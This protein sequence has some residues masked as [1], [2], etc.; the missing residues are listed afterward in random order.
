MKISIITATYNCA[1]TIKDALDSVAI[2]THLDIEHLIIDGQSV[3]ET[4]DIV[5][6]YPS[7]NITLISESDNGIYD[8]LNKGIKY[9]TGDIIG[10]LHADDV[11][12]SNEIIKKISNVFSNSAVD[13]VYGDLVYVRQDDVTR[14]VRYWRSGCYSKSSFAQGWMP[15]HPTFYV[16]RKIYEKF[17]GF[18]L[19]YYI[20][21]DYDSMLRLLAVGAINA[22]YIPEI[23]VRMRVGG[24]SNRSFSTIL[25]KSFE[26][27][28]VL[29][30]N[31]VGGILT[32]LLKNLSKVKQFWMR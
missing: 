6:E 30:G 7:S 22:A 31:R 16:R 15:P 14:V 19:K 9:S 3:D 5:R 13:A 26:D 8:A 17:G 27:I 25:R 2:Q 29:R 23:L 4:L 21:A 24:L 1:D 32:L 12:Q 11:F 18:N 10:F 20:S 28:R